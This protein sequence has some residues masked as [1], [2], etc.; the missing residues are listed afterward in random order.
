PPMIISKIEK[1]EALEVIDE[2]IDASDGIMVARGDLGIEI[3]PE[4]VP[5]VQ[6]KLIRACNNA[7]KPVITA[8]QMLD[9]MIRNPRPTR[10][11]ASDVANAILDGTDA[12]MLSGETAAGKYPVEAVRTMASIAFEMEQAMLAPEGRGWRAPAH[13]SHRSDDVTDAVSYSTCET[14]ESLGASAIITATSSGRTARS[15]ARYR[16]HTRVVAVT[17]NAITQRQLMLTWGIMPLLSKVAGEAQT[18]VRDSVARAVEAG[19]V[20]PGDRVVITAGIA[21]NLPGQTN[22]ML[23]EQVEDAGR[24]DFPESPGD[25]KNQTN[26]W[27]ARLCS[28][29][30]GWANVHRVGTMRPL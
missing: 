15:V 19:L 4:K 7:G 23:I 17:P 20:K 14:A 27:G 5:L 22:V 8:T 24:I 1:P 3:P 9:S 25:Q 12:L 13:V 28:P 2:I 10:A 21:N 6:K 18:V 30:H 11:E 29:L 16:P 26:P